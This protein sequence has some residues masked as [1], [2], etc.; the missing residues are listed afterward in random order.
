[1]QAQNNTASATFATHL[2]MING[3]GG[4]AASYAMRGGNSERGIDTFDLNSTTMNGS[5]LIF[6]GWTVAEGGID[7]YMWSADGGIT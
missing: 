6:S 5:L 3:K 1:M 4:D 7:K 2:D